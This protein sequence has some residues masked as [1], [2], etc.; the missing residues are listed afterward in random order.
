MVNETAT[1]MY[2]TAKD[3][4]LGWVDA[5][6]NANERFARLARVWIDETLGAQ[7][8][9]ATVI[10][11]AFE[12]TQ[13]VLDEDGET[14]TPFTLINRAGDVARTSYFLWTEAG[15]KA[16]ERITRV[17]QTAFETLRGVQDELSARAEDSIGAFGRRD[18]R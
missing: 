1:T 14:P 10:R 11:R 6:I 13:E 15:L 8:D 18:G 9:V 17:Y 5:S 7:Q 12:E 4:Y 2:G 16:Q 3:L